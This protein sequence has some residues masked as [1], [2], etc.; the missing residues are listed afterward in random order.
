MTEA[1]VG[2]APAIV[3]PAQVSA[4]TP[5]AS[6][7]VFSRTAGFGPPFLLLPLERFWRTEML[8]KSNCGFA[9]SAFAL[10]MTVR[11]V[12]RADVG[13]GDEAPLYA[14]Y[15]ENMNPVDMADLI[16]GRPLVL[17]VGSAS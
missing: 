9:V 11:G 15:D 4:Q 16:D 3:Q 5:A 2:R 7:A 6:D 12:A 8:T 1:S 13:V 17:A 14:T 10:I